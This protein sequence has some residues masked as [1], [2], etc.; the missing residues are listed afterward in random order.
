ML[1]MHVMKQTIKSVLLQGQHCLVLRAVKQWNKHNYCYKHCQTLYII[2]LLHCHTSFV[3][4]NITC[5]NALHVPTQNYHNLF[6]L[7]R[8]LAMYS[9][10]TY[11][12]SY[13]SIK[14]KFTINKINK[15]ANC[16]PLGYID[17]V[18]TCVLVFIC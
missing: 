12:A 15:L 1:S 7:D 5:C 8:I 2:P 17:L 16:I 13:N 6:T 10:A 14:S 18:N 11:V 3:N 9:I 4:R